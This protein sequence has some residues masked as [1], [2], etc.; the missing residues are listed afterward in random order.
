M[1]YPTNHNILIWIGT[2]FIVLFLFGILQFSEHDEALLF[3]FGTGIMLIGLG[4]Y[5]S[6]PKQ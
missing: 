4:I 3:F 6:K 2:L 5:E 1:N